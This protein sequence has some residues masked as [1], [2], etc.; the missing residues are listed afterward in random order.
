MRRNFLA[1]FAAAAVLFLAGSCFAQ[2]TLSGFEGNWAFDRD[3]TNMNREFPDQLQ[4]YRMQVAVDQNNLIVKAAV[5]GPLEV[6]E[7]GNRTVGQAVSAA[8]GGRSTTTNQNGT[9]ATSG[10]GIM[11]DT[12]QSMAAMYGGTLVL[13]KFT[14]PQTTYDL[15]KEV[16]IEPKSDDRLNGTTRLQAKASKDGHK[17][18][19]T[20]IRRLKGPRGEIET[21]S[22]ETWK[23]SQDGK[24]MTLFRSIEYGTMGANP[25][26]DQVTMVMKKV[27]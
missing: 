27:E 10:G 8:A 25:I 2:A 23:L 5:V 18:E 7:I 17:M 11:G 1:A 26:K 14:A 22:H 20:V 19:L 3:K 12:A 4:D 16:K 21:T 9:M 6:K 24:S 15:T 13:G